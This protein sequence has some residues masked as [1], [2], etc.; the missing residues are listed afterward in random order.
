MESSV[1]NDQFLLSLESAVFTTAPICGGVTN[2][3]A[4]L[5]SSTFRDGDL[6]DAGSVE[7]GLGGWRD[8]HLYPPLPPGSPVV[9]F[10]YLGLGGVEEYEEGEDETVE[11]EKGDWRRDEVGL[12]N[13]ERLIC[14]YSSVVAT[15]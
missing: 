4:P 5:Y 9:G 11:V 6:G 13:G 14:H 12:H 1:D 10:A 2:S 3:V 7:S 8:G 15:W